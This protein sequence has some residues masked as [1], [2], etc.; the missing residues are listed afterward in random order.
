MGFSYLQYTFL[1]GV[2]SIARL[3]TAPHVGRLVDHFGSRRPLIWAALAMPLLPFGWCLAKSYYS[4]VA[5]YFVSGVVWATYDLCAF[6]YL[7]ETL[8]PA[9]RSRVFASR[10]AT[11]NLMSF[12]GAAV[13]GILLKSLT[14]GTT[15]VFWASTLGRGLA[16]L[17][18][19]G[20]PLGLLAEAALEAPKA[21]EIPEEQPA[22]AA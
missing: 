19:F 18:A 5:T 11:A 13:G 12:A 15:V 1:L 16:A 21:G 3:L 10:Q 6:T 2:M 9:K 22:E 17:V 4:F 14:G 20:L 8:N 7:A